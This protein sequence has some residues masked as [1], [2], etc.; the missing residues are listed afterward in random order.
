MK[1]HRTPSGIREVS[2]IQSLSHPF[3]AIQHGS[4]SLYLHTYTP[5]HLH[6]PTTPSIHTIPPDTHTYTRVCMHR[7]KC[8]VYS[9]LL[10]ALRALGLA[11]P[12][13]WCSRPSSSQLRTGRGPVSNPAGC[14]VQPHQACHPVHAPF[15]ELCARR[16]AVSHQQ[17]AAPLSNLH[18]ATSG[19]V[20]PGCHILESELL[21]R[22]PQAS[23]FTGGRT[24]AW[25][26]QSWRKCGPCSG[27][28]PSSQA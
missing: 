10:G 15:T 18:R 8:S 28:S 14:P 22:A 13:S 3:S 5:S 24:Q 20:A 19:L 16:S 27:Y 1:G 17:K 23:G 25:V 11:A 26:G 6:T 21:P 9:F 4:S 2:S 12:Q 7:T